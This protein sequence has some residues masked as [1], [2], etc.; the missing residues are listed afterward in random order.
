M[1]LPLRSIWSERKLLLG[2][3]REKDPIIMADVGERYLSRDAF[4][5]QHRE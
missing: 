5:Y 2:G 3:L 1:V 4:E